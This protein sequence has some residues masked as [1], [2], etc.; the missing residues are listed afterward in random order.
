MDIK[1]IVATHK[2][3]SMPNDP[4]YIPLHV[5]AE[6]KPDLGYIK[7]NTGDSISTKNKNYCELT[8]LYYMWKNM[9]ADYKGLV[10]YRRHFVSLTVK[11]SKSDRI[12]S[13]RELEEILKT[14]DIIVPKKRHYYI[15]TNYSQYAHAHHHEDLDE[16]RK[17]IEERYPD[18]ITS[19]DEVMKRTYG[20]RF[21]MF[22]M[23]SE[24]L[25]EYLTWL[26]DILFELEKRVDISNYSAN[27]SRIFGFVSERLLDVWLNKTCY[28][29][30]ELPYEFMEKQNWFVKGSRFLLRKLGK[31]THQ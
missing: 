8:G 21:N 6:G 13:S 4:M 20:H 27:D 14:T 24:I 3:Y 30:R 28:Q 25:D 18:F 11:G 1:I 23:K 10:H 19:Y 9:D 15:E 16:T 29:Y 26:F 5:G 31:K 12:I 22:I 2:Q 17:I 7:D